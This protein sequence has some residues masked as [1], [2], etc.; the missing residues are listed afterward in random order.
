MKRIM[1][2]LALLIGVSLAL[3][4]Q[5]NNYQI[6][7]FVVDTAYSAKLVNSSISVLN[8]KRFYPG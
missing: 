2:S 4:A 1:L 6:K 5:N 3:H 8:A 7:G